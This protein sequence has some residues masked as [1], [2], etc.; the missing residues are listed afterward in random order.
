MEIKLREFIA[1]I[2]L[3]LLIGFIIGQNVILIEVDREWKR[4][5]S[6]EFTKIEVDVRLLKEKLHIK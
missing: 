2:A 4:N 6:K 3:A 5:M 1:W